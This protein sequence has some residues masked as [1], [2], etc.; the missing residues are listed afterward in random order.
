MIKSYFSHFCRN[1][2]KSTKNKNLIIQD[3]KHPE[4]LSL[5]NLFHNIFAT[6]T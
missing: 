5:V 6:E 1:P 3:I 4:K 2:R